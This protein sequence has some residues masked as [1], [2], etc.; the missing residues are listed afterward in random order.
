MSISCN[1]D[2]LNV[3]IQ[4][5]D[6]MVKE[7]SL[8]LKDLNCEASLKDSLIGDVLN[9]RILSMM[10][11]NL[12]NSIEL[13]KRVEA[14]YGVG[15]GFGSVDAPGPSLFLSSV[16]LY[17]ACFVKSFSISKRPFDLIS[18]SVVLPAFHQEII[19][20]R[21][22]LYGHLDDDHSLR[23]ERVEWCFIPNEHGYLKPQRPYYSGDK[24]ALQIGSR[25]TEWVSLM[26]EMLSA[27]KLKER[28][29]VGRIN[30][31]IGEV[32]IV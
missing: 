4:G 11:S 9:L 17:G 30:I 6:G 16:I 15:L 26:E 18:D 10:E 14:L 7:Y 32:T 25:N 24:L 2:S 27:T 5:H 23:S 29:I 21:H 1:L 22:K 19:D 20:M 8:D 13:V 3:R 12:K 28:E 31:A